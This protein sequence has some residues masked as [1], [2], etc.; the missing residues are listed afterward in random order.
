MYLARALVRDGHVHPMVGALPMVV[1]HTSRPQGHGYTKAMVDGGNPFFP[2]G[3]RIVGHEFH[4]SRLVV[5]WSGESVLGMERGEGV[6]RRRDGIAVARVVATYAHLHALATP[7]WARGV[8]EAARG[9]G[10]SARGREAS[11]GGMR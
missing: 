11:A 3:R 5:G 10:A 7:E 1:E 2:V 4:H 9:R 8:V 6:G